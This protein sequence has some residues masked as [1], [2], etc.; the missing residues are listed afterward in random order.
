M[1][2]NFLRAI[3]F[4]T[5]VGCWGRGLPQSKSLKPLSKTTETTTKT[6]TNMPKSFASRKTKSFKQPYVANDETRT[7]LAS[8]ATMEQIEYA[9]EF[10]EDKKRRCR[11]PNER[12]KK[13]RRPIAFK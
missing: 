6:T 9:I 12:L 4:L 11:T 3:F 7:M 8:L 13:P 10:L 5:S 2:K 1:S